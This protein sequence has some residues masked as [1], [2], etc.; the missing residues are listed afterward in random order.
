[1]TKKVVVNQDTCIGCNTCPLVDPET[2]ALDTDTYK[3][4]VKKQPTT[5]TDTV[6]TAVI[7]CPVGA[8]SIVED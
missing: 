4:F 5:I 2:F 1:M 3:A 8:I 6:D 7:S